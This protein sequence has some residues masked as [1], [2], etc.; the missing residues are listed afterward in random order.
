MKDF[1][2]S[3]QHCAEFT[4]PDIMMQAM[5]T[6]VFLQLYLIETPQYSQATSSPSSSEDSHFSLDTLQTTMANGQEL[7]L[8]QSVTRLHMELPT[9]PCPDEHS[10]WIYVSSLF[11]ISQTVPEKIY[12]GTCGKDWLLHRLRKKRWLVSK[13]VRLI[14][15]LTAI[16]AETEFNILS[17][18][19]SQ[20]KESQSP[21][22]KGKCCPRRHQCLLLSQKQ[23]SARVGK[24]PM[25]YGIIVD[26][27]KIHRKIWNYGKLGNRA[28]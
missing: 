5:P 22:L 11:Y 21:Q 2:S 1:M 3:L 7:H 27:D 25:L 12:W 8:C 19:K 6:G 23:M 4:C 20:Q 14:F 15:Y 13:S 17:V 28:K 26:E 18:D 24:L 16:K 10:S 9:N